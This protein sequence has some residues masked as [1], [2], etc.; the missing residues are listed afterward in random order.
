MVSVQAIVLNLNH[1]QEILPERDTVCLAKDR[2]VCL[3]WPGGQVDHRG[4]PYVGLKKP[5]R[6]AYIM[7]AN[8]RDSPV[9]LQLSNFPVRPVPIPF[10]PPDVHKSCPRPKWSCPPP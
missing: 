5:Q 9:A 3:T 4:F 10:H 7:P 6:N 8:G 2:M 1:V